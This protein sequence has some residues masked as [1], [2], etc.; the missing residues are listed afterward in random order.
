MLLGRCHASSGQLQG[1]SHI[2]T[3]PVS[4]EVPSALGVP[5]AHLDVRAELE[6]ELAILMLVVVLG[7]HANEEVGSSMAAFFLEPV[8]AILPARPPSVLSFNVSIDPA[9]TDRPD[10]ILMLVGMG[11]LYAR[12]HLKASALCSGAPVIIVDPASPT[13]RIV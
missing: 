9:A 8:P 5:S 2:V 13:T 10:S 1:Q 11:G 4:A 7:V 3:G 12:H 6:P